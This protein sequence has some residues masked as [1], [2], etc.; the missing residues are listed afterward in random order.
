M[1]KIGAESRSKN[2]AFNVGFIDTYKNIEMIGKLRLVIDVYR[3][4]TDF[5][6]ACVN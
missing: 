3:W 1:L 6:R 4:P 5:P 2:E